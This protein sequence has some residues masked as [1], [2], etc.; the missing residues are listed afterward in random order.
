MDAR[1]PLELPNRWI[2]GQVGGVAVDARDHV[3]ILQPPR[4]LTADELGAVQ[5]P[6]RSECCVAAPS[7]LEFDSSGKVLR[8]WG[9]PEH[10]PNWPTTEHG[11]WA[12]KRGNIWI[13]GNGTTIGIARE[14]V[15]LMTIASKRTSVVVMISIILPFA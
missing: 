4:S 8:A 2:L 14:I 1:W 12:D 9:G 11:I 5:T 15:P 13:S 10:I 7:V 6:L 3:W